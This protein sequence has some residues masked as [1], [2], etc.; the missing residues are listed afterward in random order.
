MTPW[1]SP[2]PVR[3]A[4]SGKLG[5]WLAMIGVILAVNFIAVLIRRGGF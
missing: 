1:L 2:T 3:R 4:R 5:Y